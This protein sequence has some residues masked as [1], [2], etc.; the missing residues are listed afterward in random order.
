MGGALRAIEQGFV[1]REIQ[2]SAYRWQRAVDQQK[3]IV[4]G[5]NRYRV[6]EEPVHNLLRVDPAVGERQAARL[7][8]LRQRRDNEAV[9]AAL[10]R[11]AGAAD[12]DDNLMPFILSA[13]ENY[14]TLGEICDVL[15]AA[16]GEYEAFTSF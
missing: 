4:V 10:G 9:S 7:L 5:V 6:A 12:S 14:A 3:K 1:Q 11:L 8:D 13:V 2:E 15:R 16:F